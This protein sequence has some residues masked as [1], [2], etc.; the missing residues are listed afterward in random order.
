MTVVR[1]S[2]TFTARRPRPYASKT[3]TRRSYRVG[4]EGDGQGVCRLR[5]AGI[6]LFVGQG[7]QG[8]FDDDRCEP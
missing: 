8:M 7:A 2:G 4:R 1:S 5:S 6:D 3:F